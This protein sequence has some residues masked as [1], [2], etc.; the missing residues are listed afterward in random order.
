MWHER[1]FSCTAQRSDRYCT[2][3]SGSE[4][5]YPTHQ[6]QFLSQPWRMHNPPV[7]SDPRP[8][9]RA[10]VRESIDPADG[11]ERRGRFWW[12]EMMKGRRRRRRTAME[13]MMIKSLPLHSAHSFFLLF[14]PRL[15]L[16][17]ITH[18]LLPE[19][20]AAAVAFLSFSFLP[21]NL[22]YQVLLFYCDSRIA[23]CFSFLPVKR[24]RIIF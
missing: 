4:Q 8:H 6:A 12:K 10:R 7:Q 3:G 15:W 1:S 16:S 23:K 18:H 5:K 14:T 13:W 9:E 24:N 17:L 22:S 20:C 21:P 2:T 19:P 11:G